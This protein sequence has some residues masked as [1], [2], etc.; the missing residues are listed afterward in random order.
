MGRHQHIRIV[1]LGQ[2]HAVRIMAERNLKQKAM[3]YLAGIDPVRFNNIMNRR[4]FTKTSQPIL[5]TLVEVIALEDE[6]GIPM[7]SWTIPC[8]EQEC[9]AS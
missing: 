7:P 2:A 1:T 8:P 3:G 9:A 6:L 5:P 4:Q